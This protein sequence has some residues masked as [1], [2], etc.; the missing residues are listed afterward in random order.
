MII[1]CIANEFYRYKYYCEKFEDVIRMEGNILCLD[2][3]L[4]IKV[5]TVRC[6]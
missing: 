1:L 6:T 5:Y 4:L 2:L 3:H